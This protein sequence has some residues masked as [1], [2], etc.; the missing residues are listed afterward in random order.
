MSEE[1]RKGEMVVYESKAEAANAAADEGEVA[2][3]CLVEASVVW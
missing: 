2:M 3:S 1:R